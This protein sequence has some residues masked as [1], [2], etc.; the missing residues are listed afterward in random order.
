MLLMLHGLNVQM[1]IS[2]LKVISESLVFCYYDCKNKQA[3]NNIKNVLFFGL[4][5]L[6]IN[7]NKC[8]H[9][10]KTNQHEQETL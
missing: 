2:P 7:F 3:Q 5:H 8:L 10:L 9:K 4:K 6:E 1:A